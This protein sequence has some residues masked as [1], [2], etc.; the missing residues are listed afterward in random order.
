M[1]EK[2]HSALVTNENENEKEDSWRRY[3]REGALC[4]VWL[5]REFTFKRD[6]INC[7]V[8]DDH[9]AFTPF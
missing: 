3:V 9:T 7:Y 8:L 5:P 6:V 2:E 4:C 1:N